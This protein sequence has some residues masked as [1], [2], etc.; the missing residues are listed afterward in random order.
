MPMDY[1]DERVLESGKYWIGEKPDDEPM[2]QYRERCALYLETEYKDFMAAWE[3]RTGRP[4]TAMTKYQADALL[5]R[6]PSLIRNPGWIS[7][8]FP[9]SEFG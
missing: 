5:A 9:P 7:V 3:V 8:A 4:W 2:A 6:C 1:T